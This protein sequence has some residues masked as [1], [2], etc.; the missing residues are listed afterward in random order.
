MKDNLIARQLRR[1]GL[2]YEIQ[3]VANPILKRG[4]TSQTSIYY[5][6]C[7]PLKLFEPKN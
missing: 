4:D 2:A 5:N 1:L 3:K 7:C 6:Y